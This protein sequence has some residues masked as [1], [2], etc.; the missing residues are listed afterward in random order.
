MA[1]FIAGADI[2]SVPQINM[3][4][5]FGFRGFALLCKPRRFNFAEGQPHGKT[6]FI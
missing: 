4:A 6:C 2:V 3:F 1:I 5:S